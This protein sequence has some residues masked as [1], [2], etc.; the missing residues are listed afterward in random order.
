MEV[1]KNVYFDFVP[2]SKSIKISVSKA[3]R[4]EPIYEAANRLKEWTAATVVNKTNDS[5]FFMITK[6][7]LLKWQK[8]KTI[9]SIIQTDT[10]RIGFKRLNK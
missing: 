1:L 6:T 8:S 2:G 3:I 7:V 5:L 10:D 9:P 4:I